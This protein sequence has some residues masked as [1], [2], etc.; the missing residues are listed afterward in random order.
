MATDDRHVHERF[1]GADSPEKKQ[2]MR[3]CKGA[4]GLKLTVP[5]GERLFNEMVLQQEQIE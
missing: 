2:S 1:A 3:R 5:L 4:L